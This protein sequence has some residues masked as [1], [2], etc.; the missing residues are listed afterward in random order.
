MANGEIAPR[1]VRAATK[2][3][4]AKMGFRIMS[5]A[6][7]RM[8]GIRILADFMRSLTFMG[9]EASGGWGRARGLVAD[10]GDCVEEVAGGFAA[11]YFAA[12]A[13]MDL[14]PKEI[15]RAHV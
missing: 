14:A 4:Y 12:A 6:D 8:A 5:E 15:G 2:P 1:R 7:F 3:G 11:E 9:G 13:V 10:G